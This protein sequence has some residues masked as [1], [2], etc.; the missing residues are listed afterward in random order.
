MLV[1]RETPRRAAL[2]IAS[3]IR[4]ARERRR[5]T[6]PASCGQRHARRLTRSQLCR[7]L[8]RA[9]DEQI[10]ED[11]HERERKYALEQE[12]ELLP[13]NEIRRCVAFDAHVL[14]STGSAVENGD[15]RVDERKRGH[16]DPDDHEIEAEIARVLLLPVVIR[17]D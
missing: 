14:V 11:D 16:D 13:E 4:A 10:V 5:S 17:D 8:E 12:R 2:F 6:R 1:A 15:G 7:R 3:Q 9:F